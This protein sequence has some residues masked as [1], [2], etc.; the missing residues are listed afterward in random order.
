MDGI[1]RLSKKPE[2]TRTEN[3]MYDVDFYHQSTQL[4]LSDSFPIISTLVKF[5]IFH[6]THVIHPSS[7]TF[8]GKQIIKKNQNKMKQNKNDSRNKLNS[9]SR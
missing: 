8:Q 1:K 3:K 2:T 7:H 9:T 4:H 5:D 6:K